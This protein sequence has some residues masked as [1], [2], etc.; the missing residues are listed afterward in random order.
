MEKQFEK[1]FA[2]FGESDIVDAGI[3]VRLNQTM[4]RKDELVKEILEQDLGIISCIEKAK[5]E[6]IGEL[7]DVKKGRQVLGSY[8]SSN[9]RGPIL[10]EEI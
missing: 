6:I 9:D 2:Q 3:K 5:S 7:R 8:K 1:V 10:H 4:L